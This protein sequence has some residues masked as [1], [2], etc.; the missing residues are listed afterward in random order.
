M[1]Q[2][3]KLRL[4]YGRVHHPIRKKKK[5]LPSHTHTNSSDFR[6]ETVGR[7]PKRHSHDKSSSGHAPKL[8]VKVFSSPMREQA[9]NGKDTFSQTGPFI[10]GPI[11]GSDDFFVRVCV[12]CLRGTITECERFPVSTRPDVLFSAGI[13][14]RH[15][16]KE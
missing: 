7:F 2:T 16:R 6:A 5:K 9:Y 3:T 4:C 14:I 13:V 10:N 8:I 1:V 15:W 12:R 11:D